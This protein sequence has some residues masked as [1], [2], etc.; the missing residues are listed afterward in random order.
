M[1]EITIT[2]TST[3]TFIPNTPNTP[4]MNSLHGPHSPA[5]KR[6]EPGQATNAWG[7]P[8]SSHHFAGDPASNNPKPVFPMQGDLSDD[9][10]QQ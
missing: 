2:P 8:Q 7:S 3:S 5:K 10:P 1:T 6:P 4:N 9:N